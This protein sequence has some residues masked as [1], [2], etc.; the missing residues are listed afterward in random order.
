MQAWTSNVILQRG[1]LDPSPLEERRRKSCSCLTHICTQSASSKRL[2][3]L[4]AIPVVLLTRDM[5]LI[6]FS[7]RQALQEL[8]I[9]ASLSGAPPSPKATGGSSGRRRSIVP[10]QE[11]QVEQSVGVVSAIKM[12]DVLEIYPGQLQSS[13]VQRYT[14]TL[15]PNK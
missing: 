3:K 11:P 7:A 2:L 12:F 13:P 6:K 1:A 14:E 10:Q 9:P 5:N 8:L 4:V 15:P